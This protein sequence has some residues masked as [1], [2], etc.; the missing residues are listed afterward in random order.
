MTGRWSKT[1]VFLVLAGAISVC[2][3]VL[4]WNFTSARVSLETEL[5]ITKPDEAF[6]AT[7]NFSVREGKVILNRR[8]IIRTARVVDVYADGTT[9]TNVSYSYEPANLLI[10]NR[11]DWPV[12]LHIT[13]SRS[14]VPAGVYVRMEP[15]KGRINP[16]ALREF[17][18]HLYDEVIPSTDESFDFEISV[19]IKGL[20]EHGSADIKVVVPACVLRRVEERVVSN[21]VVPQEGSS[22]QASATPSSSAKTKVQA[23]GTQTKTMNPPP[24]TP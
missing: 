17:R 15:D 3:L 5:A 13:P 9:E 6:I 2:S 7:K 12:E 14:R 20:W 18:I 21:A 4:V 16:G 23:A 24:A 19:G 11:L 8:A 1:P 10:Q 22:E